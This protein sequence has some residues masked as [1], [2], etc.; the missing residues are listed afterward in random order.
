MKNNFYFLRKKL[1]HIMLFRLLLV[2]WAMTWEKDVV[3]AVTSTVTSDFGANNV[4][5]VLT[6]VLNIL[7]TALQPIYSKVSD[8]TGRAGAYTAAIVF[9]IVSFVIMAVSQNYNALIVSSSI[10]RHIFM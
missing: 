6:T 2:S 8:M 3:N 1:R 10:Y 9:F 7:Q 5:A 4:S